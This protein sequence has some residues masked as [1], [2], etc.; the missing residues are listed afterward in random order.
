VGLHFRPNYP[1]IHLAEL[2]CLPLMSRSLASRT[3]PSLRV[4]EGYG[5]ARGLFSAAELLRAMLSSPVLVCMG[6]DAGGWPCGADALIREISYLYQFEGSQV[7]EKAIAAEY[8]IE[9]PH[10]GIR[11]QTQRRTP[12]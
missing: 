9:C 10:C 1:G 4:I 8:V 12:D 7:R 2:G 11:S 3:T 5:T 6:P